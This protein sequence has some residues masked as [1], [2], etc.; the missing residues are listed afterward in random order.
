MGK[1]LFEEY[2]DCFFLVIGVLKGVMF[3]MFDLI[4][5]V[6]IYLEMDFMD[7]LSYGNVMVFSG[8]VKILKDLDILVE[9]WD[10]FILEDIIDS[11]LMFSYFVE[12]FKY[13]K[14]KL[15]KIVIFLDKL[16][17]CKVFIKVDYVGFEVFDV[18]VVGYGLDY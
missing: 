10:I 12:L 2:V 17:G 7:V 3:F 5:C 6:D 1:L 8:E 11:G 15:I 18:F 13:C 4:K 16:I 9:G 14:V